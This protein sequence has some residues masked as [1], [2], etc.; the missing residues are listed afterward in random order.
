MKIIAMIPARSGSKALPGKNMRLLDGKPMLRHTIDAARK[1]GECS[2]IWLN[3]DSEDYFQ[4]AEGM[5]INTYLRPSE[6]AQDKSTM[7]D[8]VVDF[9]KHLRKIYSNNF[10]LVVLYPAYPLRNAED[11]RRIVKEYKARDALPM[12]G[13]K[14]P[15]THPYLCFSIEDGTMKTMRQVIQYDI[16]KYYRRQD[17]PEMFEL[18]HFACVVPGKYIDEVNNQLMIGKGQRFIFLGDE[19]KQR[20]ADIDTL[21]DFEYAEF[22]LKKVR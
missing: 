8:V 18:T 7:R 15:A 14:E 6:F 3:S 9:A 13:M 20:L 11:I 10:A 21:E 2:E 19:E 16:N 12:I 5:H 4:A 1:S 22:L 17:Y